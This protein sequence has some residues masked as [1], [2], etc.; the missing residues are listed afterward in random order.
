VVC[1]TEKACPGL[2]VRPAL[3]GLASLPLRTIRDR[4]PSTL[5]EPSSRWKGII[6]ASQG[7]VRDGVLISARS[8]FDGSV[9]GAVDGVDDVAVGEVEGGFVGAADL[10]VLVSVPAVRIGLAIRTIAPKAST[11][12]LIH[13]RLAG[14][15][16]RRLL[17]YSQRAVKMAPK[18]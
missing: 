5:T 15:A 14:R 11:N 8:A 9:D 6:G 16:R 2:R 13:W 3:T 18:A 12:H 17:L 4:L 1:R 7:L 10:F